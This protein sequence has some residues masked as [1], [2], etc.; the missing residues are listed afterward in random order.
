MTCFG[1]ETTCSISAMIH[2]VELPPTQRNGLPLLG[3]HQQAWRPGGADVDVGSV[4]SG[5]S[6]LNF[7]WKSVSQACLR[8]RLR[9]ALLYDLVGRQC[10]PR[11]GGRQ[12]LPGSW[13]GHTC[14]SFR[15][16]ICDCEPPGAYILQMTID[17]FRGTLLIFR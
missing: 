5:I 17:E 15:P 12:V 1:F 3:Y 16:E 10:L 6:D 13:E 9:K 7:A 11:P 2:R 8:L 4:G 14:I